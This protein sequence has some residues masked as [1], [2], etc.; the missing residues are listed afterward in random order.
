MTNISLA[1]ARH[2]IRTVE[3][4]VPG[5]ADGEKAGIAASRAVASQT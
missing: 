2:L 4:A 5:S 1:Q 3:V